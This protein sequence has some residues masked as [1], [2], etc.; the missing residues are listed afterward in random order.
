[1]AGGTPNTPRVGFIFDIEVQGLSRLERAVDLMERADRLQGGAG[2]A[3]GMMGGAAEG[4]LADQEMARDRAMGGAGGGAFVQQDMDPN[5]PDPERR[6]QGMEGMAGQG[7][8]SRNYEEQERQRSQQSLDNQRLRSQ[9]REFD[10]SQRRHEQDQRDRA[11][12]RG[13]IR[14]STGETIDDG[15]GRR[16]TARNFLRNWNPLSGN[17]LGGAIAANFFGEFFG[18]M[19]AMFT[20]ALAAKTEEQMKSML[21]EGGEASVSARGAKRVFGAAD[22]IFTE[23]GRGIV[24]LA[25][26][27]DEAFG[28]LFRSESSQNAIEYANAL[29]LVNE[30]LAGA[31]GMPT[32][33]RRAI[34]IGRTIGSEDYGLGIAGQYRQSLS[35]APEEFQGLLTQQAVRS[36]AD[37]YSSA[38]L[39][40][41]QVA[42]V[43]SPFTNHRFDDLNELDNFSR[44]APGRSAFMEENSSRIS[45]ESEELEQFVALLKDASLLSE[46]WS[47]QLGRRRQDFNELA[48]ALRSMGVDAE[49]ADEFIRLLS[50]SLDIAGEEARNLERE[51][52]GISWGLHKTAINE[53]S[54][55]L[56]DHTAASIAHRH[57]MAQDREEFTLMR[58]A[59][60]SIPLTDFDIKFETYMNDGKVTHKELVD[61][62]NIDIGQAIRNLPDLKETIIRIKTQ[63]LEEILTPAEQ[64]EQT[65]QNVNNQF[66]ADQFMGEGV[67]LSGLF[68]GQQ[69]DNNLISTMTNVHNPY[70]PPTYS[71]PTITGGGGGK[72]PATPEEAWEKFRHDLWRRGAS[73]SELETL[74]PLWIAD[75]DKDPSDLTFRANRM[76][77]AQ[78][79]EQE[80]IE[81]INRPEDWQGI[82]KDLYT[83]GWSTDQVQGYKPLWEKDRATEWSPSQL[84]EDGFTDAQAYMRTTG[85]AVSDISNATDRGTDYLG[86]LNTQIADLEVRLS[87]AGADD[88]KWSGVMESQL[89]GLKEQRDILEQQLESG[90]LTTEELTEIKDDARWHANQLESVIGNVVDEIKSLRADMERRAKQARQGQQK[91]SN[92]LNARGGTSP[93][94][95]YHTFDA[96]SQEDLEEGGWEII[97]ENEDGSIFA[98]LYVKEAEEEETAFGTQREKG[99]AQGAAGDALAYWSAKVNDEGSG[100]DPSGYGTSNTGAPTTSGDSAMDALEALLSSNIDAGNIGNL[101]LNPQQEIALTFILENGEAL[102]GHLTTK[103]A[104]EQG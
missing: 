95:F 44:S 56:V 23:V 7:Y 91:A 10:D 4:G 84:N 30:A 11:R 13:E 41:S 14:L 99:R 16:N 15:S 64:T 94:W 73:E 98:R 17:A 32:D 87:G 35:G 63:Y 57:Q 49:Q 28:P 34:S 42:P 9:E 2:G 31:P 36:A 81:N 65:I 89:E 18:E 85:A 59:M 25:G 97:H 86:D 54:D 33:Q 61:L 46:D 71:P 3:G 48:G 29:S 90:T 74:K 45:E 68:G 8:Q 43:L 19:M 70:S 47:G 104:E 66:S 52:E 102:T 37:W 53:T 24:G 75:Y 83:R 72:P 26:S 12:S 100:I 60:D 51:A 58:I 80:I 39:T 88:S 92:T 20:M 93:T 69:M 21:E 38:N 5:D 40:G 50:V 103:L 77:D 76:T 55:A 62:V 67:P 82:E 6:R 96:N 1:M 22:N 27:I 79:M 78:Q 101:G